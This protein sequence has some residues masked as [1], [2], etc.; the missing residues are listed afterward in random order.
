ME[1]PLTKGR[2]RGN[3]DLPHEG[4]GPVEA[5]DQKIVEMVSE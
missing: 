3:A 4:A 1:K 2:G 5:E